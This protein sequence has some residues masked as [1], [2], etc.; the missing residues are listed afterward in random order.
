MRHFG[1]ERSAR[2]PQTHCSIHP[3]HRTALGDAVCR[4]GPDG[5]AVGMLVTSDPLP[6]S[7]G[8]FVDDPA[9]HSAAQTLRS[10]EFHPLFRESI[11]GEA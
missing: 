10:R 5:D 3:E 2:P 4:Q 11:S 7:C 9:H 6:H 8:R 1:C